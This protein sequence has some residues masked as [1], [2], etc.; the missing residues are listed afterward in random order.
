ME[1]GLAAFHS[2]CLRLHR[3]LSAKFA[4]RDFPGP[5]CHLRLA[6]RRLLVSSRPVLRRWGLLGLVLL[7]RPLRLLPLLPVLLRRQRVLLPR[8]LRPVVP[9]LALWARRRWELQPLV[10]LRP[11]LPFLLPVRRL[12][13]LGLLRLRQQAAL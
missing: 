13:L 5:R 12:R 11:A 10:R 4:E 6:L 9:L 7:R 8:V 2:P 1:T 3:W